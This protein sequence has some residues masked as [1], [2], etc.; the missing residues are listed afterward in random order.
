[1]LTTVMSC[2]RHAPGEVWEDLFDNSDEVGFLSRKFRLVPVHHGQ[3]LIAFQSKAAVRSR[4]LQTTD[5]G[6]TPSNARVLRKP[7]SIRA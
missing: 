2:P 3:C 5:G 4:S 6:F 1:M 7:F